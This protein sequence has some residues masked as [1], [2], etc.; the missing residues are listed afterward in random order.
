MILSKGTLASYNICNDKGHLVTTPSSSNG[1][2]QQP[3]QTKHSYIQLIFVL[4]LHK[5]F[6]AVSITDYWGV[7]PVKTLW[8]VQQLSP[9]PDGSTMQRI[10][11]I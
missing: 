1:V 10:K 8:R 5:Q 2:I 4:Q 11:W 3:N 6:L 7:T 9:P